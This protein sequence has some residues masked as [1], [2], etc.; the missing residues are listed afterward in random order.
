MIAENMHLQHIQ[1][2]L[3][4]Q[5]TAPEL[6]VNKYAYSSIM[7]RTTSMLV[8][9]D[10]LCSNSIIWMQTSTAMEQNHVSQK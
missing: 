2:M 8:A 5:S 6:V 4:Y 7:C 9:L 3:I 10:Y 1:L